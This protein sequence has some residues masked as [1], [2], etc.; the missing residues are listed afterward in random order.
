MPHDITCLYLPKL[1]T[2]QPSP[3]PLSSPSSSSSIIDISNYFETVP[4]I[5]MKEYKQEMKRRQQLY[6]DIFQFQNRTASTVPG[7]NRIADGPRLQYRTKKIGNSGPFFWT[8]TLHKESMQLNSQRYEQAFPTH[9]HNN[10][11]EEAAQEQHIVRAQNPFSL[12]SWNILSQQLYEINTLQKVAKTAKNDNPLH[13]IY[14]FGWEQRCQWIIDT[15]HHIDSDIVCLQEVEYDLFVKDLLPSMRRLGYDGVVQGGEGVEEIQRRKGKSVRAHV[16]ATFWKRDSFEPWTNDD[17]HD[18]NN[19]DDDDASSCPILAVINCHL[20]GHPRQYAARIKQL[21]HSMEDL[22]KQ[23]ATRNIPLNGL[24]ISGDFNCELQSSACSTY[25]RLGRVGRKG[26]LGGVH[27]TAAAVVPTTL[28]ES[29][30]AAE[31]LHPILE[32]GK[33]IPEDEMEKVSPHAFRHNSLLS[34]YPPYLGSTDA[35]EHFTFCAN[36]HRPVAGLD[37][38]WFS[39]FSL[40][41]IAL[42]KPLFSYE[43]RMNALW[44]GL[45]APFYPSDHLP[46]GAI[47]DWNSCDASSSMECSIDDD[48]SS[49]SFRIAQRKCTEAGIRELTI[50]EK[51]APPIPKSKSPIM[52][53]A[54]LDMLLVTCP[55]DS[56][57][58]RVILESIVEDVPDV[59][60]NPKE[61][62]SQ[63]QLRK[64]SEMRE[65]KKHLLM[66]ASGPCRQVL[67][68][69]LKLQKVVASYEK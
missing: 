19:D 37:Q 57:E 65:R 16:V 38:I 39:S 1:S 26:G 59:P 67:Q 36:P 32:W 29:E 54:E 63:E 62:P 58:Q 47:L 64:L 52:A 48:A 21:Q 55:F 23:K 44:T 27:G 35:R 4:D 43:E 45:P 30:E 8:E 14:R 18:D 61:K 7:G 3:L 24:C 6:N 40:S 2:S 13:G 34:A 46:I 15:L 20:E 42:R 66:T 10:D 49:S 28:L 5:V 41:R 53:Y 31:C 69:I 25:L 60:A 33:P 50:T 11:D 56:D 17:S 12:V 9:N 68:R 22:A 51:T